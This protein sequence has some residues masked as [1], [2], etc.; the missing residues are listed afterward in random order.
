M[1]YYKSSQP[2]PGKGLALTVYECDDVDT[3]RRYVTHIPADGTAECVPNPVVKEL[4]NA[5]SLEK[6]TQEE[7]ERYWAVG[8][9]AQETE[10]TGD[11]AQTGLGYFSPDMSISEAMS[12]H[13]RVR[14][15]FAAF[16]L[17]GCAHCS[18][19]EFETLEQVCL[20]YGVDIDLLLEVLESLMEPKESTEA[21]AAP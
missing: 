17:G 13:P 18:I 11:R 4:Y 10:A 16:H 3:V 8:V 6:A 9:A 5:A 12:V 21:G 1:R 15:V 19:N 2:I 14:E 20:A 7:F